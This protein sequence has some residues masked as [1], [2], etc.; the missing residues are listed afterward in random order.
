MVWD[1]FGDVPNYVEPF[2]GSLAVLLNRPHAPIQETVNDIDGFLCNFWRALAADPDQVAYFA[3]WP[4]CENDLHARHLWL[5]NR[6]EELT[7]RLCADPDFFDAKIAGWWVWGCG[8]WIGDGWCTGRGPWRAVEGKFVRER[9]EGPSV[10]RSMPGG[11]RGL[12]GIHRTT[13]TDLPAYLRELSDRLRKVRVLSGDWRRA[14]GPGSTDHDGICGI[15]LD[16]PYAGERALVYSS[17]SVDVAYAVRDWAVAKG[18]NPMLRI[19]LCGYN[20]L[21]DSIPDS[22]SRYAWS[23]QGGYGNQAKAGRGRMNAKR[24]MVWFS[25]HCLPAPESNKV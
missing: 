14:L 1:R 7:D 4:V 18:D 15:F 22:W 23:A 11:R 21:D 20:D 8:L 12:N 3:Q 19:A 6:R 17:D 16:P 2:A 13:L 25:P 5:V 9:G 10:Q 24:E